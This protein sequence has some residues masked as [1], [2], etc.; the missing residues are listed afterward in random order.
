M[1]LLHLQISK[2]IEK[3]HQIMGR[4][5]KELPIIENITITDVAAEGKALAK[6]DDM[7]VFVPFVVPGDVVDL[8]LLWQF[9]SD[10]PTVVAESRYK[11]EGSRLSY[12]SW[13]PATIQPS[14]D[15][16]GVFNKP[17]VLLVNNRTASCAEFSTMFFKALKDKQGA[18]VTIIGDQTLGATGMISDNADQ[19]F[20]SGTFTLGELITTTTTPFLQNRMYDGTF[21]EGKGIVPDEIVPFEY[22]KFV[23]G[24]DTRLNRAFSLVRGQ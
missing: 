6:V 22:D 14:A 21:V 7:V 16:S 17:I 2:A 4:K 20:D 10:T 15:I 9:I 19:L 8:Q 23:S 13:Q 18:D 3:K 5:K 24:E 12:T 1:L 11:N